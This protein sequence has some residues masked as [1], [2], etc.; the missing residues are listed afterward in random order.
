MHSR[1]KGSQLIK[2][3]EFIKSLLVILTYCQ[4]STMYSSADSGNLITFHVDRKTHKITAWSISSQNCNLREKMEYDLKKKK[5]IVQVEN[6]CHEKEINI[7][8]LTCKLS[9]ESIQV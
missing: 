1:P 2:R 5:T 6:K 3:K 7:Q 8:I 4:W 9:R